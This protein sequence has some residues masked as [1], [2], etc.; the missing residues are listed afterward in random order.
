MSSEGVGSYWPF[1]TGRRV[2]QANIL[3]RQV[4]DTQE[5]MFVLIPNQHIGCWETG[6]APQWIAREYLTR[7]GSALF[8]EGQVHE[9]RCPLLGRTPRTIHVEGQIV[10][11]WFMQVETQPEVGVEGYDQGAEILTQFFHEQIRQY[12]DGD[13]DP[14]ATEI[15]NACLDGASVSDYDGLSG[16]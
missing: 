5:T 11:H 3:F 16:M 6:F 1:A 12:I 15:I 14:Q 7:R 4:M 10:G 9:A 2:D 13:L 8:S